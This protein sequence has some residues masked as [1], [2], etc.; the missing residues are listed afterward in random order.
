MFRSRQRHTTPAPGYTVWQDGK[1]WRW[2]SPDGAHD[3]AWHPTHNSA[4][5]G[6]HGNAKVIAAIAK[7]EGRS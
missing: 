5:N 2:T 6:S 1:G 4:C 7:R 3:S